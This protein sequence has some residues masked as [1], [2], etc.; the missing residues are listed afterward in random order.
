VERVIVAF[1]GEKAAQ[2]FSEILETSYTAKCIICHSADE[3][4]RM[5]EKREIHVVVSGYKLHNWTAVD[6]AADLPDSVLLLVV[7]T[8]SQLDLCELDEIFPIPAPVNRA[9]LTMAVRMALLMGKRIERLLRPKRTDEDKKL[10]AQAK[11]ALMD[12]YH[13]TEEEA[14]RTLQ[15]RSM[16]AGTRLPQAARQVLEELQP[17]GEEIGE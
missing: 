4:K 12:R 9:D 16:D 7:A 10:I 3:V 6:L 17:Q 2:R 8:Q 15:K 1:E 5:V 14:H 13:L 11:T